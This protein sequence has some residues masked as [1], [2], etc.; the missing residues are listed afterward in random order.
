MKREKK[1]PAL[2]D[3]LKDI[4]DELTDIGI[5]FTYEFRDFH[6]SCIKT[7]TE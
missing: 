7:D 1:V 4:K 2:I 5:D 6:N 3:D